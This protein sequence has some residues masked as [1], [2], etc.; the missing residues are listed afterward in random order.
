MHKGFL[1]RCLMNHC[2]MKIL[3]HGIMDPLSQSFTMHL[4]KMGLLASLS[5]KVLIWMSLRK[6]R[7]NY[8]MKFGKFSVNSLLGS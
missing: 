4:K 3:K 7:K 1:L 2:L 8:S 5:Q 6:G